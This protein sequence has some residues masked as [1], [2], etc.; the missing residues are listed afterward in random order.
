MSSYELWRAW[1]TSLPRAL[2]A[3]TTRSR[4]GKRMSVAVT[5]LSASIIKFHESEGRRSLVVFCAED[6]SL[7]DSRSPKR[8]TVAVKLSRALPSR[9]TQNDPRVARSRM[10][11]PRL[12]GASGPP[13]KTAAH[14]RCRK[15]HPDGCVS[16]GRRRA[17]SH[18][19]E[20]SSTETL[21]MLPLRLAL[22]RASG[23]PNSRATARTNGLSGT[24]IPGAADSCISPLRLL[25]SSSGARP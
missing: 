3:K 19:S 1:L 14:C 7:D 13:S 21:L 15:H 4:L 18:R 12:S 8:R 17:L 2:Q 25:L 11:E 9:S 16:S 22:V 24:R 20:N 6:D 23:A 10:V 5:A